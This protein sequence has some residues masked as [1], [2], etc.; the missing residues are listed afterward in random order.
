MDKNH[1]E[2][3]IYILIGKK[4]FYST[5]E[6]VKIGLFGSRQSFREAILRGNMEVFW[7]SKQRQ[8]VTRESLFKYLQEINT[9]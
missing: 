6:L 1:L 8:V 7:T 5:R 2:E 4:D 3:R 9:K